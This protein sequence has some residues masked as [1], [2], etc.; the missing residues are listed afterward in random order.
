MKK[1][2]RIKSKDFIKW[3]FHTGAD[4]EQYDMA[5]DLGRSIVDRL[6]KGSVTITPQ[7]ILDE[8][9]PIVIRLNIVEGFEDDDTFDEIEDA[10]KD[11]RISKDF[12]IKLV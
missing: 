12:E 4:Q 5:F 9:E 6:L 11:G 7:D 10:I 1:N 2:L 8:C 3:M